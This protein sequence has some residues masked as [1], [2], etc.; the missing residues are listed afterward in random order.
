MDR[1]CIKCGKIT[2]KKNDSCYICEAGHENWINPAV[3]STVFI[4][5]DEKVLYGVRS[6]DPGKGKLDLPGGFIE[7]GESAERAAIREVKEEV[8]VDI[9]LITLLGTYPTSYD[10]RPILNLAFIANTSTDHVVPGDDMSGG[11][12]VWR[13]IEDLPDSDEAAAEWFESA[14]K[15]L[16]VWWHQNQNQSAPDTSTAN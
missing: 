5:K 11:D 4:I 1:H 15:D 9:T 2:A 7:V 12:P 16:L 10:G 13:D 8:G 14:Q 6:Q 3:G